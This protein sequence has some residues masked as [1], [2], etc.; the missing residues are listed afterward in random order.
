MIYVVSERPTK[1]RRI[2]SMISDHW[3]AVCMN[4]GNIFDTASNA[5]HLTSPSAIWRLINTQDMYVRQCYTEMV[6]GFQRVKATARPG[7]PA[8]VHL[9]GTS[10]VGKSG[11]LE[12]LL[13]CLTKEASEKSVV[14]RIRLKKLMSEKVPALDVVL[15]TDGRSDE[16]DNNP[17]DFCC[18]ILWTF[19]ILKQRM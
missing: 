19:M 12:Y 9:T 17:V 11:L 7:F 15:W 16:Y 1:I 3:I 6:Q 8:L 14:W 2:G 10:G 13:L 18:L 4:I 5:G